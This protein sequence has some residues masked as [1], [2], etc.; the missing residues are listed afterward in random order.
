MEMGQRTGGRGHKTMPKWPDK[1]RYKE[2]T[3]RQTIKWPTAVAVWKAKRMK[4]AKWAKWRPNGEC[5][6]PSRVGKCLNIVPSTTPPRGHCCGVYHRLWS[7]PCLA[8]ARQEIRPARP[9]RHYQK[10][11]RCA[12][13]PVRHIDP[14]P[15]IKCTGKNLSECRV[16]GDV[17]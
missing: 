16:G 10:R 9:W 17:H 2:R 11:F 13:M 14:L 7:R 8:A 4:N 5:G 12:S 6:Q 1:G 15:F 3:E